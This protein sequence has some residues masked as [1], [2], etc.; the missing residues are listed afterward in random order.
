MI[1]P[2][3]FRISLGTRS[4]EHLSLFT[5]P[6]SARKSLPSVQDGP[7]SCCKDLLAQIFAGVC[8]ETKRGIVLW[9]TTKTDCRFSE[10]S[11]IPTYRTNTL[12]QDKTGLISPLKY[13]S[14]FDLVTIS[15]FGRQVSFYKIL[16]ALT[17]AL[18][19]CCMEIAPTINAEICN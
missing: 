10:I 5:Y 8:S 4:L 11:T 7:Y 6:H 9:K 15:M 3:L 14:Q 12:N 1:F 17:T 19:K 18:T 16:W 2:S 13:W